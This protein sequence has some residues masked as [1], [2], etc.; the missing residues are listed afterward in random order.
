[1]AFKKRRTPDLFSL[2]ARLRRQESR[3]AAGPQ[4]LVFPADHFDDDCPLCVAARSGGQLS[5]E[6]LDNPD[7]VYLSKL[8][9]RTLE[10]V[11]LGPGECAEIMST[12]SLE[13]DGN[14]KRQQYT[15]DADGNI[16]RVSDG[17]WTMIT[18]LGA[19]S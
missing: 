5:R 2:S 3:R 4:T 13:A 11:T 16:H 9:R 1:M 18:T 12:G 6:Q 7:P 19:S 17:V 14:Y 8:A 10:S 15:V